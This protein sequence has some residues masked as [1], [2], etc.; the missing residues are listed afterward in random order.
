MDGTLFALTLAT[1]LGSITMGGVFY[2]FSVLV[3][4]GLAQVPAKDATAVM[5]GIN[6][7]ALTPRF[8]SVFMGTSAASLGLGIWAAVDWDGAYS[9]FLVAGAATYLVAGFMLT[10]GYHVPRNE[11]LDKVVPGTPEADRLW[12]AYLID[13]TRM[14]HVRG[15]AG[16]VAGG[17]LI[18]GIA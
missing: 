16:V 9:G 1:A 13:W 15:L 8:L 6:R 18:A 12:A 2:G 5:Q 17:L 11:A 3:M 4:R 7:S 10:A 14:N